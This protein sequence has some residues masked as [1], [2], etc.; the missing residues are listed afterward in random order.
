M[1]TLETQGISL[2]Y[3]TYGDRSKSPVLLLAG[4]GG[5]GKSWGSQ[6]EKFAK[7]HFVVV[8]DHRG[9]GQTTR[10][11]GGYTIAQLAAD[12]ASLVEHLGLGPVHVV[13]TSTGGAIGQA[14]A[15]DHATV[16]C[17]LTMASSFARADAY[18]RREF[19]LRRKLMAEADAHTIYNCYALF[20]FSPKFA[21]DYP[22]GVAQWVE[23][24]AALPPEREIAL[25]RI[26]MIM[27]HDVFAR[28]DSIR[29][30]TLV[31]CG[32]RDFCTPP[33]LSEEIAR[34]VPGA[35]LVLFPGSGHFIHVEQEE[36][37][38]ETVRT[39]VDRH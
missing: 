26:D 35:G 29:Q 16:V 38:F 21:S 9:T 20:L 19:A 25:K 39:F 27:A 2:H 33:H 30:P 14:M 37:F 31:V 8:P 13:G 11:V 22:D 4:L 10:S 24:A 23:R 32:D 12:M 36:R 1:A 18:L 3:E 34:A 6:V 7:G 28:L 17:T 5:S 15:L